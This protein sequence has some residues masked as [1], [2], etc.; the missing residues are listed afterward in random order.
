MFFLRGRA[1]VRGFTLIE[2]LVV[3][4]IIAVLIGL[5]VPAVQKVREAA[6]RAQCQNNV[7]QMCL[8]IHEHNDVHH[9][10]P[11][12]SGYQGQGQWSGQYTSLHFQILP[13]IEQQALFNELPPTGRGDDMI[14]QPMPPIFH[15]PSDFT[16]GVNGSSPVDPSAGLTSYAANSQAFG[17]QWDGGPFAR[18]PETFTDGTSNVAM[19]AERY[20][21]CGGIQ[22]WWPMAHDELYCPMYAYNWDFFNNWTTLNRLDLLFQIQPTKQQCDPNTT[23]TAHTGAMIVG[24]ADGHVRGV[25]AGVS[26]QTWINVTVPDDGAPLGNDWLD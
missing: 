10:C 19:I 2:L 8:A 14:H 25:G 24:M 11:L 7:R 3:I 22:L 21:Y 13:F 4:A 26:L 15:C 17:N 16:T 12:A 20:G 1:W 18:I 6:A 5:L 23:Q 9:Y